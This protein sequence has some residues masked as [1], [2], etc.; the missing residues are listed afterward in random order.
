[1]RRRLLVAGLAA[2]LIIV[3]GSAFALTRPPSVPRRGALPARPVSYVGLYTAGLPASYAG[4]TAFSQA[5]GVSPTLVSYYSGWY[6]P[7]QAGFAR[8][9]SRHGAVPLVQINPTRVSLAAIVAGQYDPYLR[10][11]ARAVRA[12]G[13]PVILGFGHEMNGPWYPW[14]YHH[15]PAAVFVAA[16]RHVVTVFRAAGAGNVTWLWTVNTIN[17]LGRQIP[18][19]AAW[20]PGSAYVTWVGI[21]GY[22]HRRSSQFA[23]VFGPTIAAVRELTKDPIIISETGAG[24]ATDQAAKIASLFAGVRTYDLLGFLWFDTIGN[25]DYRIDTQAS[26]AAF[27]A[28]ARTM[29]A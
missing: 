19:P 13:Q 16:W 5:T 9:V 22:F 7:F 4:V 3:A 23:S 20:W 15:T 11:F 26:I 10:S 28:G 27:R 2:C 14:G 29:R 24:P 25:A 17:A 18:S 1:M 8:T 21:D 6:E 12:Y